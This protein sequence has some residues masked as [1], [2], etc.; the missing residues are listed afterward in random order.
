MPNNFK[1]VTKRPAQQIRNPNVFKK[2]GNKSSPMA[3]DITLV[4]LFPL[5]KECAFTLEIWDF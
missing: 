3:T 2:R 1:T 5:G 4:K